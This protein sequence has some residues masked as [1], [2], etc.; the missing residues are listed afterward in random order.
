MKKL[1]FTAIAVIAFSGVSIASNIVKDNLAKSNLEK[2]TK[3]K[4][5]LSTDCTLAKFTAYNDAIAAGFSREDALDIS[6]S[7]YFTC[8]GLEEPLPQ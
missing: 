1:V 6:Y 7:V 5:K 2:V 3:K 8:M 4:V